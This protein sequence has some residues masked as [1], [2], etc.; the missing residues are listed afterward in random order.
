M[1]FGSITFKLLSLIAGAFIITTLSVLLAADIQL[2]QIIDKSQNAMYAERIATILGILTRSNERLQKTGLV[3]AYVA[4]FKESAL[5]VLRQTYYKRPHQSIYPFILDADGK[6]VI[7]QTLPTGDLS[8]RQTEIGQKMLASPEGDFE[9]IYLGQQHWCMFKQFTEWGWVIGYT[10][11]LKIKYAD[12]RMFR[13]VLVFIMGWITTLALLTLSLIVARFTKPITRLTHIS[14]QIAAGKLDQQIELGGSD[15]VGTL[16]RS[17]VRMRD[18][19]QQQI[20]ELTMERKR[21]ANILEGTNAG[22]WDWN[23]QTG[24]VTFNE[25]WAEIMGRT[26]EELEP[27]DIQTWMK[28]V[29]PDDLPRAQTQLELHFSGKQDYYDIEFRQPHKDDDWVWVNARGKV[30]EWTPDGKPLRMSGTHVDITERKRTQEMLIQSEKM[31]SVGGLAAGMAHEINN[32]LGGMMQTASVMSD[33]LSNVEL[34]ANQRAAE[35]AGTSM[36]AIAAFMNARGIIRM[37]G[38][39][40]ESGRRAAEIVRN[41]L[42]FARKS[43]ATFSTHNLAE[44]LD[45]TVDLAGSDYDLKK[46]FDFRQIEIVREYEENL[47]EV[48]CESG[49]IQQVFLN[50]LRNGAEAMQEENEELSMKNEALKKSRFV[51][52]L[53]HEQEAERVRIEVADNGPGMNAAT[54]KR[55]FE[56]FFTTKPVGQ[57]TGLGLSVSY[58]IITENHSGE[59]RVESAPGKGTIF[60]IRLPLNRSQ[61]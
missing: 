58:F 61:A 52:R 30:V 7:H 10:V 24:E 18:S 13:T 41:M 12:A 3:E 59:M 51:L 40:S 57:G 31:L 19:I 27:I 43:D 33:R 53:T 28:N 6:V 36:A 4:D 56:P 42:S 39:I 37:L 44:L 54:R 38:R 49:K 32:P 25:R 34:P 26:L 16:A 5:R 2:T 11:P 47:P 29:H 55:I 60:I 50:I 17:F 46:K 8:L 48:S 9:Y 22:T 14:T 45:Q 1:R 35:E 21:A 23:V 15:E 20:L